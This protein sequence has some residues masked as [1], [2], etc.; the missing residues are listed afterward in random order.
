MSPKDKMKPFTGLLMINNE[1]VKESKRQQ[2]QFLFPMAEKCNSVQ[3][4][5]KFQFDIYGNLNLGILFYLCLSC[6][7]IILMILPKV[8]TTHSS[9]YLF[10]R[11]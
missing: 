11:H 8:T 2:H 3:T 6:D 10:I 4:K 1:D 5:E 9:V 7:V